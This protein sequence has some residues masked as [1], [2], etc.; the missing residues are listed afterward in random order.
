MLPRDNALGVLDIFLKQALA[1]IA[2]LQSFVR[3]SQT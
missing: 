1:L 3:I 2:P